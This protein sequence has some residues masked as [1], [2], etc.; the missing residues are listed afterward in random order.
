MTRKLNHTILIITVITL[1]TSIGGTFAF[2]I[3]APPFQITFAINSNLDNDEMNDAVPQDYSMLELMEINDGCYC[4]ATGQTY[5]DEL[6]PFIALISP[7]NNSVNPGGS[8]IVLDIT[9][10]Y[11]QGDPPFSAKE[12][13]YHWNEQSNTTLP[14]PK[15]EVYSTYKVVLPN[16]FG[17]QVLYVYAVDN[18]GNWA[19]AVFSFTA[20]ASG[21]PPII[22]FI[23]PNTNNETLIGIYTFRV[24]VTDDFGLVEVKMQIDSRSILAMDYNETSGYYFRIINVSE[25]TNGYHWLNVTA[26]DVDWD[27]HTVTERINFTSVGGRETALVSDPPEWDPNVSDLPVNLTDYIEEGR[28]SEYV[29]ESGEIYFNV[30]ITDDIGIATVDFTVYAISNFNTSTCEYDIG[31]VRNS[32][33]LSP[34][35]SEG[36]WTFYEYT[37]NSKQS[38]DS[39]YLCEFDVQDNDDVAN[40]LYIRVILEIDNV[41][42][43]TT[44]T[45]TLARRSPSF[46]FLHVILALFCPVIIATWRKR[47]REV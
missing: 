32:S 5:T 17:V 13:R 44:T 37:W 34:S 26:K 39:Y 30:S 9:D 1:A 6:A 21:D 2:N 7:A 45:T 42:E 22:D 31:S 46:L 10:N 18:S 33:S 14:K 4:V 12:V 24:N 35:G 27:Q 15:P 40:H 36:V 41:E 38:P 23:A 3:I 28:F 47:K 19:S 20:V 8:T 16:D 43:P 11:P 29:A 25:L